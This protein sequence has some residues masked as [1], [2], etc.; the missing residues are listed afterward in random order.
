[1]QDPK[2]RT[3]FTTCSRLKAKLIIYNVQM[4]VGQESEGGS[5]GLFSRLEACNQHLLQVSVLGP[6]L[7]VIYMNSLNADS[8]KLGVIVDREKVVYDYKGV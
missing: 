4:V 5:E 7:C 2:E 6:L 1:M 8:T 3:C